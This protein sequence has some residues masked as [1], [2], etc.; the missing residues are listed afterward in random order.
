M[1]TSEFDMFLDEASVEIIRAALKAVHDSI[2]ESLAEYEAE[3][4]A[5]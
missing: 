2:A 3:E 5:A 1:A 4:A